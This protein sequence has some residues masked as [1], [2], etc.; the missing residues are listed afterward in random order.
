MT[1]YRS[2]LTITGHHVGTPPEAVLATAVAAVEAQTVV[3]DSG[4]RLVSGEPAVVVRHLDDGDAA[5]A[6]T[7][8]TLLAAVGTVATTGA[9]VLHR[10]DGGRWTPVPAGAAARGVG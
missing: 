3:E 4:V 1:S 6:S 5:A 10:R 8:A 7:A 2:T 9:L